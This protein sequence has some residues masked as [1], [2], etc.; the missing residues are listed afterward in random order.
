MKATTLSQTIAAEAGGKTR[1]QRFADMANIYSSIVNRAKATGV[2]VADIFADTS[3]FNA[4]NNTMPPGTA[5]LTS[6]AEEAI[7]YVDTNGVTHPGTYYAT[8]AAVG[9]LPSKLVEIPGVQTAHKF[10]VDPLNRPI[11]TA[12][13]VKPVKSP[14][15]QQ[16]TEQIAAVPTARPETQ[17]IAGLFGANEPPS[18]A[19][20]TPAA[21]EVAAAAPAK[22]SLT[23]QQIEI[24]RAVQQ[25][26]M[27][28]VMAPSAKATNWTG[29]A[30]AVSR[31]LTE[32]DMRALADS[33]LGGK[34]AESSLLNDTMAN[35]VDASQYASAANPGRGTTM[36]GPALSREAAPGRMMSQA[37]TPADKQ[38]QDQMIAAALAGKIPGVNTPRTGTTVATRPSTP[39]PTGLPA[40]PMGTTVASRPEAGIPAPSGLPAAISSVLGMNAPS[41]AR[42]TQD[43]RD[44]AGPGLAKSPAQAARAATVSR[45]AYETQKASAGLST[46]PYD[47]Q[48]ASAAVS[49]N[50]YDTQQSTAG[51]SRPAY[52][53][54]KAV[55]ALSRPS[56]ETQKATAGLSRNAYDV[57][58][59]VPA[60][61]PAPAAPAAMSAPELASIVDRSVTPANPG[62]LGG[63]TMSNPSMKTGVAREEALKGLPPL[64]VITKPSLA[65]PPPQ[66]P[67]YAVPPRPVHQVAPISPAAAMPTAPAATAGDVYAGRAAT[68]LDNTGLNTVARD[69]NKTSVTNKFGVETVTMPDGSQAAGT[70]SKTGGSPLSKGSLSLGSLEKG[71]MDAISKATSKEGLTKAATATAGGVIGGP[72]GA[73]LGAQLGGILS[74]KLGYGSKSFPGAPAAPSAAAAAAAAAKSR[75]H[76]GAGGDRPGYSPAAQAAIDRGEAGLY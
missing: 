13:G 57:Q 70:I 20:A 59:G 21:I 12:V 74:D 46:N 1:E 5:A 68:A 48:K 76:F 60:A 4:Y 26:L 25:A 56:Y 40:A 69:G 53:V 54:Q 50:A 45:P 7:S 6:L 28:N 11:I 8:P 55:A 43:I 16:L 35:A 71:I 75:A 10:Y 39:A 14:I 3:Q 30:S 65:V 37:L 44:V 73:V 31:G 9:N 24:T 27:G 15:Q 72:L 18:A 58:R 66:T 64:D 61:A 49:R 17:M 52:D 67:V 32:A 62:Q 47:T 41:A 34:P 22:P 38:R 51:V 63:I 2:A 36:G 23:E 33:I 29:P 19:A 42:A